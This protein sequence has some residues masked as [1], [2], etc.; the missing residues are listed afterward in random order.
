MDLSITVSSDVL[1]C[2]TAP[3]VRADP[4]HHFVSFTGRSFSSSRLRYKGWRIAQ[5]L[6]LNRDATVNRILSGAGTNRLRSLDL[7]RL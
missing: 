1:A 6:N 4:T 2:A 5:A 7:R 3:R